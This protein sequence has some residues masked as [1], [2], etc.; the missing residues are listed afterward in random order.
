LTTNQLDIYV[1]RQEKFQEHY[2]WNPVLLMQ[3]KRS[4]GNKIKDK[5]CHSLSI[6]ICSHQAIQEWHFFLARPYTVLVGAFG[7]KEDPTTSPASHEAKFDKLDAK[8]DL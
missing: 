8:H 6:H 2:R 4:I 1:I 3:E 5:P 7:G